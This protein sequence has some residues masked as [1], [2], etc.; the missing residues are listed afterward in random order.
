MP[1]LITQLSYYHLV[2]DC[3]HDEGIL[4][5]ATKLGRGLEDLVQETVTGYVNWFLE[6]NKKINHGYNFFNVPAPVYNNSLSQKLNCDVALVVH[7]FNKA[8]K[9]A[10]K[11]SSMKIVD[12]YNLTSNQKRI[13][14]WIVSLR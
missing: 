6:I 9:L 10:L 4:P 11:N 2:I 12:V 8:L 5:A 3:R 1:Y 13:F 14:E 7:L